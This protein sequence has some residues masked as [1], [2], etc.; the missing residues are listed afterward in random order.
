MSDDNMIWLAEFTAYDSRLATTRVLRVATGRGFTTRPDD[1]IPNTFYEGCLLQALD[2]NRSIYAPGATTGRSTV[3]PGELIVSNPNGAFDDWLE[4]SFDGRAV[5][6]LFGYEYY[7]YTDDFTTVFV[8]TMDFPDFSRETITIKLRDRQRELDA[9]LQLER[10]AGTNVLPAG[11]EGVAADLKGKVKPRL[12]GS[13][14]GFMPPNVNTSLLAYQ[15]STIAVD[16]CTAV[17][18]QGAALTREPDYAD[19]TEFLTVSP[20]AGCYRYLNSSTFS[21]FRLGSSPAGQITCD[22]GRIAFSFPTNTDSDSFALPDGP[23]DPAIWNA[24]PV[25]MGASLYIESNTLR[26]PSAGDASLGTVST[27]V[28]EDVDVVLDLSTVGVAAGSIV[29]AIYNAS[30]NG[31]AVEYEPSTGDMV[32]YVATG[33]VPT[34]IASGTQLL[35]DGDAIGIRRLDDV[36]QGWA[37]VSGVW[38]VVCEVVDAT[39]WSHG[40]VTNSVFL[41][42]LGLTDLRVSRI[43][44]GAINALTFPVT[45]LID[46]FERADSAL[47]ADARYVAYPGGYSPPVVASGAL[48]VPGSAIFA[49][50]TVTQY[51]P[52]YQFWFIFD[53]ISNADLFNIWQFG[54][55]DAAGSGYKFRFQN[56]VH[57]YQV[58]CERWESGVVTATPI[59]AVGSSVSAPGDG[60]GFQRIG[61]VITLWEKVS[62]VWSQVGSSAI[63]SAVN[64]SGSL[65]MYSH[66]GGG[67]SFS[68]MGGGTLLDHYTHADL[69]QDIITQACTNRS[70]PT[71]F[72]MRAGDIAAYR[73]ADDGAIGWYC[74][75]DIKITDALD[76]AANRGDAWWSADS[77]GEF[78]VKQLEAPAGTPSLLITANEII[79]PFERLSTRDEDRGIPVYRMTVQ[80][81][82]N[83]TV[84]TSDIAGSVT[85]ARR[86]EIGQE[87]REATY[88]DA[89]VQVEHLLA[90]EITKSSLYVD[91][92]SAYNTAR[93]QQKLRSQ[94]RHRFEVVVPYGPSIAALDL[95]DVL[96]LDHPRY[97]LQVVGGTTGQLMLLLGIVPDGRQ[98]R[99]RLTLWGNKL[100]TA[101]LLTEASDEY[102]TE[103]GEYLL[104]E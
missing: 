92:Q 61:N 97:G 38:S 80:W 21:G 102:L 79:P 76:I 8:G 44:G 56:W 100:T 7:Q 58:N 99:A 34:P 31:Y 54:V 24:D 88:A 57:S 41:V 59:A 1:T 91:E 95:G 66:Q 78:R 98:Q 13:A 4:L 9:P 49:A 14:T 85:E 50:E 33:G 90:G 64:V 69:F 46:D 37:R 94:Q 68:E 23:V 29:V 82:R 75:D 32:L 15:I 47:D 30:I 93:R 81:G 10:F 51:G 96:A 87:W 70:D 103:A 16:T 39:Y 22:A 67:I 6:I 77:F 65:Y 11:L 5:R 19:M 52:D 12:Y 36:I 40:T 83:Y 26:G 89:S 55:V 45:P 73:S 20:S 72:A 63:D 18:D 48:S 25:G 74:D 86:A 43:Y 28:P 17:Y 27:T 71:L 62:G 42:W 3:A 101:N 84:Q 2:V 104:T 53:T 60:F 35:T